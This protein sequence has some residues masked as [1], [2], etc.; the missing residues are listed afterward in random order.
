VLAGARQLDRFRWVV[1]FSLPTIIITGL[2]MAGAYRALPLDWWLGWPG[3]L[4][5]FK[6][7]LII[8]LVV[9]FIMCPLFRQ[10][11]PVK[12]VC[13]IDDL[14]DGKPPTDFPSR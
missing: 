2:I 8:A 11:S 9:V 3:A 5:P 1:R 4:I 14:Y 13:N 10:C 6:V 7:L 12:G